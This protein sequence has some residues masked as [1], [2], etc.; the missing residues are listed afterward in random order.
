MIATIDYT[1]SV[2]SGLIQFEN[3]NE[4]RSYPFSDNA[5]LEDDTGRILR[6]GVI[7]DMHLVIPIGLTALLSS[8]YISENMIS[9]CIKIKS[10]STVVSAM[11]CVIETKN[12]EPYIPYRLE[13][14]TGSEDVGGIVTFGIIDYQSDTGVYKFNT[15]D[16]TFSDNVVSK[17]VPARL[18]K[19]IDDRTGESISGDVDIVFPS[20]VTSSKD[21]TGGITLDPT[22]EARKEL[23]SKCDLE[24]VSNPCG[25]T[26]VEMINGVESDSKK[27]IVIWFH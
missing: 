13:K 19:L 22:N 16:I 7:S 9:V 21:A 24:V 3:V 15:N 27:R 4:G 25:A 6:D 2:T 5:I 23:L 20:Y 10:G 8:V 12:F 1:N 26:P 17:Y 14:L 18:R 11:S